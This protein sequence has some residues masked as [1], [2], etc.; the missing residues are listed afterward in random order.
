MITKDEIMAFVKSE[1]YKAMGY[2]DMANWFNLVSKKDKTIF[3]NSID[4][5]VEQG[6]L[7]KNKRGKYVLPDPDKYVEGT[8]QGH[9]K[10]FGFVIPTNS[11]FGSDIFISPSDL[12]GAL[13]GDKVLVR[14][15]RKS[16]TNK[17][18]EG[19]IIKILERGRQKVVGT[20]E[21]NRN[22]GFVIPDNKKIIRDIYIPKS[23]TNNAKTGDKVVVDIVVWPDAN[24]NPEGKITEILGNAQSK[25]IDI[26]SIIREHN[27]PDDFPDE[28][29]AVTHDIPEK[30]NEKE[31]KNRKDL[32]EVRMVTIDGADAKDLDDAVAVEKLD[33]GNYKLGVHIADVSYYVNEGSVLDKE[34][35]DRGTSVYLIDRVIPMLP[36][37]LSNGICSLNA[38]VDRLSF[39]CEM[40]INSEGKV[41]N[42]DVYKS[43]INVD[44]RMTYEDVTE[45]LLNDNKEL[46]ERYRGFIE[47]F[48][49]MEELALI[50]R[51]KRRMQRGAIDFNFDETKIILDEK[52]KPIEIKKYERNISNRIIEEFML[53]CNETVAEHMFWTNL[54][55]IYRVHEEPS[56]T[57]L[58]A[59]SE[60]IGSF[61]YKIRYKGTIHPSVL[62]KLLLEIEGKEEESLL[63]RLILR[64]MQQARYMEENLGH[65]GLSAQYYS[66]FT[67]PIRRYPDLMIHRIMS[68]MLDQSLTQKKVDKISKKIGEIS[69]H[70]SQRERTAELAERD[71]HD[72]K[73]CEY[74]LEKVDQEF[75]GIISSVTSFGFFVELDNTIEGLVRIQNLEDDYYI[76]DEKNHKFI[77]ERTKKMYKLGDKVEIIVYKVDMTLRQID[78]LIVDKTE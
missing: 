1:D 68:Y 50:L 36:R 56:S 52:G 15:I 35:Y 38:Q 61:G 12:M 73:K 59:L 41:V 49:I 46:K 13:D 27:L 58:L 69:K 5:L 45:I 14:V 64:A 70:C 28:V 2:K 26:L 55:F 21:D 65:F 43:V 40:E 76:Y 33:N 39:S 25:G 29:K 53:V 54:P 6:M 74:M 16:G 32:R 9:A 42:H 75:E 7:F 66:H 4:E 31:I 67:S 19:E 17:S 8:L 71:T 47:D 62:Q 22:F 78:F 51:E 37:E 3:K 30:I 23:M 63:S 18:G 48:K 60:F 34:A 10:G 44:E 20:Y 11:L 72:L 77:G 57:K 24:R